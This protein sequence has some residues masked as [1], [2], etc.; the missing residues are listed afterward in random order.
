MAS[1]K[2]DALAALDLLRTAGDVAPSPA[3]RRWLQL[4]CCLLLSGSARPRPAVLPADAVS[5][6]V[7]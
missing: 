4:S 3:W 6:A 5:G 7:L 2:L 1:A